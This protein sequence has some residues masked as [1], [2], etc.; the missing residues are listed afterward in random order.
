MSNLTEIK[1]NIESMLDKVE[2]KMAEGYSGRAVMQSS[3]TS[4][5]TDHL[6]NKERGEAFMEGFAWIKELRKYLDEN[7]TESKL[8]V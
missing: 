6:S 8:Q 5:R 2:N 3:S 4:F 7:F 1:T